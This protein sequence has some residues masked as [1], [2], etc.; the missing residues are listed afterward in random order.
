MDKAQ[1]NRWIGE[2]KFELTDIQRF[3][4]ESMIDQRH[5]GF[6]PGMNTL[7]QIDVAGQK[8]VVLNARILWA[9]SALA[10]H[11]DPVCRQYAGRAYDYLRNFFRDPEHKGYY[12]SVTFDGKPGQT[13]KQVY[14]QAF[15]LYGLCEYFSLTRDPAIL[16]EAIDLFGLIESNCLNQVSGGYLEAFSREWNPLTDWRL[17]EKDLNEPL[18]ANTHLHLLEAYTSLARIKPSQPVI[19]AI[20]RLQQIFEN[21]F[22]NA[23]GHLNLFF[24]LNWEAAGTLISYGHDI[25]T[26]WLLQESNGVL[27]GPAREPIMKWIQKAGRS[28]LDEALLPDGSSRYEADPAQDHDDHDRHWWVQAE[29]MV[30]LL[31]AYRNDG[32]PRFLEASGR[33][34]AYILANLKDPLSGEWYWRIDRHGHWLPDDSI[35]GFWKCPYHNTRACLEGIKR[36]SV[37]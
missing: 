6:L 28:Y 22:L 23:N 13:R 16:Q 5:G 30:G 35:A 36:L 21:H 37:L 33:I 11:H 26:S 27:P 20:Q 7:H 2:L 24:N 14:A 34:W 31:N 32:D 9:F 15:V 29:G 19:G 12:W 17:S 3:W 25:E 10:I 18:S 8:G 1:I 4:S